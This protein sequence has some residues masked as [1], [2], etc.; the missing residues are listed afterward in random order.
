MNKKIVIISGMIAAALFIVFSSMVKDTEVIWIQT[1][2]FGLLAFLLL[3]ITVLFGE[4]RLVMKE[5]QNFKLFRFHKP[6]AIFATFLVFLH[7]VSAILDNYKWGVGVSFTK[8]L[9]FSF[10]DKW[11]VFLSL[12]TLAFY[13]MLIIASTSSGAGFRLLGLKKVKIIHYFSYIALTI[14]FIHSI[15]LGTDLKVSQYAAVLAP[16]ITVMY[17]GV[18]GL[19][20]AR[21]LNA[22]SL[23]Q[24][25]TEVTL[26]AIFFILLVVGGVFIGS[27]YIKNT[28][29]IAL[30]EKRI[31]ISDKQASFY[32]ERNDILN[33]E[34]A[35]L[36]EQLSILKNVTAI[37][38]N[39]GNIK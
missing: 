38:A 4:I 10:S 15:N 21:L 14:A 39:S 28:D 31:A 5:K 18:V 1:R 24:Q 17:F 27:A 19:L 33:S 22:T 6:V 2:I 7:F 37:V 34:T 3:F 35:N 8:Y 30:L 23:F 20:I 13:L 12:G 11:L 25:Q 16:L 9:G 29:Q 32:I 26:A 36:K